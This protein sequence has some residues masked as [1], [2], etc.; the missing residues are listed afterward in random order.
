MFATVC[1]V[2]FVLFPLS[3]TSQ[4]GPPLKFGYHSPASPVANA[5]DFARTVTLCFWET[6]VFTQR[7]PEV[8][9]SFESYLR[10][11]MQAAVIEGYEFPINCA[12]LVSDYY[13]GTKDS[14][15]LSDLAWTMYIE[16]TGNFGD[17]C[18]F[19]MGYKFWCLDKK[20]V[21]ETKVTN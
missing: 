2:L 16:S 1:C 18:V 19:T 11:G 21:W 7:E 13:P 3:V 14:C 9:Q 5:G 4:N 8:K 6:L 12:A 10:S 17:H 15:S 20:I